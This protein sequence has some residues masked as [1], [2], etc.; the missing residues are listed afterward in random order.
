VARQR[1]RY[2]SRN[3]PILELVVQAEGLPA[4]NLDG[5]VDSGATHTFLSLQTA[6]LLG[7]K[8]SE[9]I[10]TP[11]ATVADDT[12]VPSW[13]THVPIRAQVQAQLSPDRPPEPWGPIFDLQPRFMKSAS[14]LWGQE[15]LGASFEISQQRFLLPAY[16]V[17][18][19]WAGM[20]DGVPR[21]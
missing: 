5:I 7:L 8:R 3:V 18:E 12:Q 11:P 10:E 2:R 4:V 17:L 6:H 20:A 19:Y 21:S 1:F 9:L 16:F 15:D 13:I 14:P